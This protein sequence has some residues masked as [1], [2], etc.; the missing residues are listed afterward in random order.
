MYCRGSGW[1]ILEAQFGLHI[2]PECCRPIALNT[3]AHPKNTAL[4]FPALSPVTLPSLDDFI[5]QLSWTNIKL[6]FGSPTQAAVVIFATV[7]RNYNKASVGS[8]LSSMCVPYESH[9]GV[10]VLTEKKTE[11]TSEKKCPVFSVTP[12]C[13]HH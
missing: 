10:S 9:N 3:S 13:S 12:F 11:M 8:G 5:S 1:G 7:S 2:V 4:G 6:W